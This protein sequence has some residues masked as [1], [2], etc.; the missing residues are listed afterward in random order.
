MALSAKA[1]SKL[2]EILL[3]HRKS[4]LIS[5]RIIRRIPI[6][7]RVR[8]KITIDFQHSGPQT[9][10]LRRRLT[11]DI[12]ETPNSTMLIIECSKRTSKTSMHLSSPHLSLQKNTEMHQTWCC[13]ERTLT[14]L[15]KMLMSLGWPLVFKMRVLLLIIVSRRGIK[16]DRER[17]T[18][19]QTRMPTL[20]ADKR[21]RKTLKLIAKRERS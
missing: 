20:K 2:R 5:A 18:I 1:S 9:I 11:K 19:W 16:G 7:S 8:F 13:Q 6:R 15:T 21:A 3:F 4:K 14:C 12:I 17:S 10:K